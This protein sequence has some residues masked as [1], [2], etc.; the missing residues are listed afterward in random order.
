MIDILSFH[1]ISNQMD[2]P[3]ICF[4]CGKYDATKRCVLCKAIYCGRQCQKAHRKEHKPFCREIRISDEALESLKPH[5]DKTFKLPVTKTGFPIVFIP[6]FLTKDR[7]TCPGALDLES[8][9][10]KKLFPGMDTTNQTRFAVST[11]VYVQVMRVLMPQ[12][13]ADKSIQKA[14]FLV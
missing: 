9:L 6:A 11:E 14:S 3:S 1:F 7:N 13:K 10:G 8:E 12:D 4:Y 5:L 2:Y